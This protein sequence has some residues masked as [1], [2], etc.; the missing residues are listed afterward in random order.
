[1]LLRLTI[2]NDIYTLPDAS[3]KQELIKKNVESKLLINSLDI[4]YIENIINKKG[5]VL[6]NTCAIK[7]D[8]ESF[9]VKHSFDS[10]AK[11]ILESTTV[12]KTIGFKY[13]Y[14]R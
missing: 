5:Q 7:V 3:G 9:R 1:M 8:Q 12:D 11:Q 10:I 4:K 14:K 2:L 13:K 6:K